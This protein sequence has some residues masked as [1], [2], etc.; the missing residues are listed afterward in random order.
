MVCALS[1][2][3]ISDDLELDLDHLGDLDLLCS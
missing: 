2:R 1:N 3:D